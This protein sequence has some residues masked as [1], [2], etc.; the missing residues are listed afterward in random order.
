MNSRIAFAHVSFASTKTTG[1][2]WLV[3]ELSGI[4]C[5]RDASPSTKFDDPANMPRFMRH[6]NVVELTPRVAPARNLVNAAIAVKV[7]EPGIG[8]GLQR[9]LEIFVPFRQRCVAA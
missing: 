6:M 9:P 7:V 1:T 2:A 4:L 5:A 8:I 3:R